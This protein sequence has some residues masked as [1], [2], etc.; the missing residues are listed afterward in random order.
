MTYQQC[1][2]S[3]LLILLSFIAA[4]S[5]AESLSNSLIVEVVSDANTVAT[6]HTTVSVGFHVLRVSDFSLQG[7]TF[8]VDLWLWFRWKGAGLRPDQSFEFV[9]GV[10]TSRSD[11]DVIADGDS[12]LAQVRVQATI[13]HD[14]DVRRCPMDDHV[15][16][17]YLE[18][19]ELDF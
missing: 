7:G 2:I 13:F 8:N 1:L 5:Q 14:F 10:I 9:N 4:N 19:T 11:N 18:D 17:L 16:Q 6:T 15:V 3:T 12:N